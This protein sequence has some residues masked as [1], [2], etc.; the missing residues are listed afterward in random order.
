MRSILV[1]IADIF[2]HEPFQMP[3]IEDNHV[4]QQVA[5]ATPNPALGDAVLPRAAEGCANW[6][7][8][9]VLRGKDDIAAKL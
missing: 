2:S 7:A 1:V 6:L 4:I 8:S 9:Q 3:L 5:A